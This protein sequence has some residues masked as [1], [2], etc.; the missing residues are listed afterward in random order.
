MIRGRYSSSSQ[1]PRIYVTRR[2][3]QRG[4]LRFE[5]DTS[6]RSALNV[7][8][9]RTLRS[10][11]ANTGVHKIT[12]QG[13]HFNGTLTLK[14]N[15]AIVYAIAKNGAGRGSSGQAVRVGAVPASYSSWSRQGRPSKR[16][17]THARW[18]SARGWVEKRSQSP[19]LNEGWE[20]KVNH[21]SRHVWSSYSRAAGNQRLDTMFW[22]NI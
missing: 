7:L 19:L 14:H 8:F 10:A 9:E 13:A 4:A 22:K 17:S 20:S 5:R 11:K 15:A 6:V 12:W 21:N 18:Y 1:C 2:A 16:L 3:L